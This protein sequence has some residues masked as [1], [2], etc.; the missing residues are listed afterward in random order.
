MKT[1]KET[2]RTIDQYIA[3]FPKA[4]QAILKKMRQT[5]RKAAPRAEETI[6]YGIPTFRL[7]G[8][9]LIYFA[10]YTR[11]V[12]VYPAPI[13][14]PEFGDALASYVSGKG[15]LRFPLDRPIPYALITRVVK[16]RIR[17]NQATAARR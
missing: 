13:G 17:E 12:A 14:A 5:I 7:N 8:R 3:A 15:T 6:S 4:V 2:P 16:Y 11:H 1:R 10:A 9:Y